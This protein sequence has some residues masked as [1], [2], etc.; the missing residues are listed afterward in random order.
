VA[1]INNDTSRNPVTVVPGKLTSL[2]LDVQ[3]AAQKPPPR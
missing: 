2:T 3:T 1:K